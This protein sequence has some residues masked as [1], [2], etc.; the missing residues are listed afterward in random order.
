M[1]QRRARGDSDRR[2]RDL[3]RVRQWFEPAFEPGEELRAALAAT[4]L[5]LTLVNV[6]IGTAKELVGRNQGRVLLLTDRAIRVVGRRFW[7]RRFRTSI[8]RYDLGTV[9]IRLHD[10]ALWVSDQPYYIN[11]NGF[12]MGGSVGSS[13]DVELFLKAARR[14]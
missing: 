14:P 1:A 7:R 3:E 5:R 6:L 10:R 9:G 4:A 13:T 8:A 2:A 12:Q 11:P